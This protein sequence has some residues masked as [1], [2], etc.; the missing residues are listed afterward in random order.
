MFHL[1]F[2]C[3]FLSCIYTV[4]VFKS[5]KT[6]SN[7]CIC[8]RLQVW[9]LLLFSQCSAQA[10]GDEDERCQTSPYIHSYADNVN[11]LMDSYNYHQ[12]LPGNGTG[13]PPVAALWNDM[14]FDGNDIISTTEATYVRIYIYICS[15]ELILFFC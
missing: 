5:V 15:A 10:P 7:N 9:G 1:H 4:R 8:V 2:I 12:L 13:Y 14:S 6:L 11:V 3:I